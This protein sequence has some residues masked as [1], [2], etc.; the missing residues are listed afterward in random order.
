MVDGSFYVDSFMIVEVMIVRNLSL[1]RYLKERSDL[2]FCRFLF[3]LLVLVIVWW[4][5]VFGY[6]VWSFRIFC[7]VW[8]EG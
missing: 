4:F 3:G 7:N 2:F 1:D 5:G 8:F 6:G